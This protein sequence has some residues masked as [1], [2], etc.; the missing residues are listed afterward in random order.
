MFF[1]RQD[2]FRYMREKLGYAQGNQLLVFSGERRCGKTSILFQIREGLLGER[3]IPAFV[4]MQLHAAIRGDDQLLNVIWEAAASAVGSSDPAATASASGHGVERLFAPVFREMESMEPQRV[5][6][7]LID[8]YELIETKIADGDLTTASIHH[9]AALLESRWPISF[10]LTGSSGLATRS[11]DV[12]FP[13][14]SKSLN[15]PIT[16]LSCA[17]TERLIR[18][19]V[20]WLHYPS[21]VVDSMFRA[22]A[23]QPFYTQVVCQ[24]LVDQL[25]GDEKTVVSSEHLDAVLAELSDNP[26]PQ[27]IY[28]WQSSDDRLQ[29][30]MSALA[31]ALESA[32]AWF[33]AREL[34]SFLRTRDI[35][36][37][38]ERAVAAELL[39]LGFAEGVFERRARSY[40]FRADLL[41]RWIERE[42]SIWR[43]ERADVGTV[44]GAA[45]RRSP[46]RRY[47]LAMLAVLVLGTATAAVFLLFGRGVDR[48]AI[49]ATGSLPEDQAWMVAGL[50]N[51]FS[52]HFAAL[53]GVSVVEPSRRADYLLDV[54]LTANR[55]RLSLVGA[56][57]SQRRADDVVRSVKTGDSPELLSAVSEIVGGF[58][59]RLGRAPGAALPVLTERLREAGPDSATGYHRYRLRSL[60]SHPREDT[61]NDAMAPHKG[62]LAGLAVG[63]H[64]QR[65]YDVTRPASSWSYTPGSGKLC[66]RGSSFEATSVP[67]AYSSRWFQPG[68]CASRTA[69]VS[70][71]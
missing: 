38:L 10:I 25:L 50:R 1:G 68:Y 53:E 33:N 22:T 42:H 29:F 21:Q 47:V 41:R 35:A 45:R 52:I 14:L 49:R 31:S 63:A 32:E 43:V 8:E 19:P 54:S 44:A 30:V 57:S 67:G 70:S 66:S 26:L 2:D 46:R 34:A 59:E 23:G 71:V 4:D 24:N 7:L 55:Q 61:A 62:R 12:W 27:M 65:S 39:E 17:D 58:A 11:R 13:L 3:F 9:L 16:H 40:R 56:L 60:G 28:S 48:V 51:A 5:L 69:S 37:E 64:D 6:L 20:P 36:I 15:R 18:E